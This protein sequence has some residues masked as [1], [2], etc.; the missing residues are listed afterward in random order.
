M[1]G[2]S[3]F[4]TASDE[5]IEVQYDLNADIKLQINVESYDALEATGFFGALPEPYNEVPVGT[6]IWYGG[7]PYICIQKNTSAIVPAD[8]T[9]SWIN[10]YFNQVGSLT[11]S[12]YQPW[13]VGV[14]D[15]SEYTQ[16]DDELFTL[17]SANGGAWG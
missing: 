12:N 7:A 14:N 9:A 1:C 10:Y 13:E 8:V 2:A 11:S 6:G 4:W 3:S 5:S 17:Y 16:A 15:I